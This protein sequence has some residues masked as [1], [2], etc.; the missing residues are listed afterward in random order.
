MIRIGDEP[1]I[2]AWAADNVA[3]GHGP[4]EENAASDD[5]VVSDLRIAAENRRPCIDRHMIPEGWVP[6][7]TAFEF[8]SFVSLK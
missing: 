3:G 1:N 7:D 4:R 8:A 6:L 2:Q 5:A